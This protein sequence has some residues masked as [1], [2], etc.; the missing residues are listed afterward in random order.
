[1]TPFHSLRV[2]EAQ[3]MDLTF[4]GAARTVTGSQHLLVVNN[5]TI[6][7]DCGLYQGHRAESYE[8]NLKLPYDPKQVDLVIL[9]HAHIDHSGNIPNLV[10][11][12]FRG[13]IICTSA[14]CD[15]AATMLPDSGYI[16]ERDVDY[17]RKRYKRTL[18]PLYTRDDALAA[19]KYFTS[20]SYHHRRQIAPDIYL[21][22]FDAGH[23]LGSCIVQLEILDRET[24]QAQ[25]LVFSGD[26]GR[27]GIPIIRDP[28]KVEE[29]DILIL[30]STY[31]DRLHEPYADSEKRLEQIVNE[32]YRRGGSI[33]MPAFAVGRTQQLVLSLHRLAEKGDIPKLPIYVDSPLAVDATSVFQ[34]HPECYDAE[35]REFM[36]DFGIHDPFGFSNLKYTRNV[37]DSKRLNFLKEPHIVISASGMAEF[38]RILHHLKNRIEDARNTI[39]ITGWQAPAT[40]G[41]RLVE[42]EKIVRIFGE[43]YCVNAHVEVI[44]GFSGHADRDELLAWVKKMNK[45]PEHCFL[46][47]GEEASAFALKAALEARFKLNVAVPERG[48]RFQL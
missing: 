33:V 1:L 23:M 15:L 7:L 47:H 14:T 5:T 44:D 31:G 19:L 3:M 43:E 8:R 38:G 6:L 28:E 13:D 18:Q 42:Q 16:Q 46:V 29:A 32:T 17:L 10:K 37:A 24:G 48:Q 9:S 21:T 2:G 26:L 25:K 41:R 35:I 36:M 34:L 40:L 11:Q 30:E 27:K 4:H 12:G 20:Q 39:L 45:K 22:L